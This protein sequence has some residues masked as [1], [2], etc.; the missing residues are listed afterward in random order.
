MVEAFKVTERSTGDTPHKLRK[1]LKVPGIIYGD[2]L[3]ENISFKIE[4]KELISLFKSNSMTS[5]IPISVD[6]AVKNCIIKEIQKDNFGN[7]IHLDFQAINKHEN[8]KL[9]IPI[10]FIGQEAIA[11]KGLVFEALET[12]LELHGPA[13]KM[14]EKIEFNISQLNID[15]KI[16]AKDVKLDKEISIVIDDNTALAVIGY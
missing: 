1:E 4:K 10:E 3:D 7:V 8:V 15:D 11:E 5:I 12:H 6:D 13:D 16:L 14:P 2:T 9:N